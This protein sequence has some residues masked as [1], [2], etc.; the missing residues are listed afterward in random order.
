VG[1]LKLVRK[2]TSGM[3]KHVLMDQTLQNMLGHSNIAW[4]LTIP[5]SMTKALFALEKPWRLQVHL[6]FK[7]C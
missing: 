5:V 4:I 2:N 1:V 6:R 7:V 3:S